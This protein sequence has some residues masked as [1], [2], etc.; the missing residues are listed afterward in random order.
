MEFVGH[1]KLF[2]GLDHSQALSLGLP[3]L[4]FSHVVLEEIDNHVYFWVRVNDHVIPI[5]GQH[6]SAMI[7]DLGLYM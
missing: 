5:I 1:H 7:A 3:L 4:S 6:D 2:H